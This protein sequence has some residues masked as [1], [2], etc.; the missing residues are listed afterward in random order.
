MKRSRK[1]L[2]LSIMIFIMIYSVLILILYAS[3]RNNPASEIDSIGDALWFSIVTFSTVGYGDMTPKTPA[4]YIIGTV[5]LF[6]S[7]GILVA[8]IGYVVSFMA[9]EGLPLLKLRT[10]KYD[11][12]YYFADFTPESDTLARDILS[13]DEDALIIYGIRKDEELEKPDYPC[14]FINDSPARIVSRKKG[15]GEECKL[16]FLKENDIGNNLKAVHLEELP[17]SIYAS[18]VSGAERMAGNIHLF[19]ICDCCARSYWREHPLRSAENDIVIIGFGNYGTA[20][21]E[22]AILTNIVDPYFDVNYHIFGNSER[23]GKLHTNLDIAFG[24]NE[25]REGHDSLYF[26]DEDWTAARDIIASAD[27]IIICED[28]EEAGWDAMW[29]IKRYY[30]T[31]GRID[32]RSN[33]PAPGIATF[34]T[35]EE[36]FTVN[37]IV[38]AKLNDAARSMNDLY[39]QSVEE[40]LDWDE[41]SD[42]LQQSKIA[43]AD[44]LPV[45]IR[46]LLGENVASRINS[47]ALRDSHRAFRAARKDA[48]VLDDLRKIEHA[49]WV[50]FYAYYNWSYGEEND[51]ILREDPKICE[52]EKLSEE[53][54]AYY[55]RAWELLGEISRQKW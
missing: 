55:D 8:L 23:F 12:W 4:G 16:F 17:A 30:M 13:E 14:I 35:N 52:Y 25:R 46:I 9:N 44:H 48:S 18:T 38:R 22:R 47:K 26:H 37:Q 53:Q 11:N 20:L 51:D 15:K 19:H 40:S 39:R 5:F 27:R 31:R 10:H 45:K 29:M 7:M 50:R 6:M 32:L 41:L 42:Q 43:T 36:I 3:E 49:R 28:D 21:L 1:Y 33:R 34:G 2:L 54:K 24:I